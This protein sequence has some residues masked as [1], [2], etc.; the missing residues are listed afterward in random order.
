MVGLKPQHTN[1][2]DRSVRALH[3]SS[4]NNTNRIE[5]LYFLIIFVRGCR[6]I[7]LEHSFHPS[8]TPLLIS[9]ETTKSIITMTRT[10]TFRWLEN[11]FASLCRIDVVSYG[12]ER[13]FNTANNIRHIDSR[14]KALPTWCYQWKTGFAF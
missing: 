9:R 2:F 13:K 14:A 8:R 10:G 12:I 7:V 11:E 3:W 6:L 1:R 4:Y 5:E